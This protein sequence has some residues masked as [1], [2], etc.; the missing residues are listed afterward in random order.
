MKD[1]QPKGILFDYGGTIDSNGMHW[2]EVIRRAYEAADVSIPTDS[3]REAY[4]HGERTL[5][6]NP[7][8]QP[9][10]TFRDMMRLKI[11]LQCDWLNTHADFSVAPAK[12]TEIADW[13]YRYAAGC[14]E[15]ARPVI[16][17]LAD[18]YPLVLVSNFYGNIE[19]VLQD[20]QLEVYFNSIIESAL[21]GIRKPNPAIFSLGVEK[22]NLKAEKVVVIGDSYDKDIVPA[23]SI[24]CKT[25]WL[26]N[27][28]WEAYKGSETADIVISDFTE[29]RQ[30]FEL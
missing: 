7:I 19:S 8:I 29:L 17:A 4:V 24:G 28:G 12:A 10:H 26:K 25:I 5:G 13:C 14:I 30:I 3:F 16:A 2:A 27:I 11:N 15:T 22:L 6:K 9:H 1:I 21:V 23:T 18:R 20:F